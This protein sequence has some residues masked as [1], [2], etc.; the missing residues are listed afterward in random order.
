MCGN[1]SDK[2]LHE[3]SKGILKMC[4]LKNSSSNYGDCEIV[5]KIQEERDLLNGNRALATQRDKLTTHQ[6]RANYCTNSALGTMGKHLKTNKEWL[7]KHHVGEE[8]PSVA[9]Q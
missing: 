7:Q 4:Q 3:G 8:K 2:R 6:Y 5:T 9:R 1:K